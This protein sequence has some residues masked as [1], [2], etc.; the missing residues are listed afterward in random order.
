MLVVHAQ[1]SGTTAGAATA[2]TVMMVTCCMLIRH[3]RCVTAFAA[4]FASMPAAAA[5]AAD[6]IAVFHLC[7]Q[8]R[9]MLNVTTAH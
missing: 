7:M 1:D 5:A 8:K 3:V 6:A 4:H 2:G 9:G